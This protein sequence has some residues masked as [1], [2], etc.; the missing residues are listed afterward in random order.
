MNGVYEFVQG[1]SPLLL[2]FPHDGRQLPPEVRERMTP[3]ALSLPDTDWNV[4]TT[5]LLIPTAL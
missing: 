4:V 5:T 1:D 2:S 3:A